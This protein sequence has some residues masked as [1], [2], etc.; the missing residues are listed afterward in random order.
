MPREKSFR[1]DLYA[2]V[3]GSGVT[4]NVFFVGDANELTLQ[5][6]IGSTSTT[7]VQGSNATGFSA[8]INEDDWSDMTT[9]NSSSDDLLNIEPGFRWIRCQRSGSELSHA[10]L[11][12][13]GWY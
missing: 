2:G 7:T 9:V 11:G 4:S 13:R 5:L 6:L 12:G 3:A 1:T 8:S 10:V